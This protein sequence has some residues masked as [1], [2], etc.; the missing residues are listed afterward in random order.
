MA[1][2][3]PVVPQHLVLVSRGGEWRAPAHRPHPARRGA[4]WA[5]RADHPTLGTYYL[6]GRREAELLFTENETNGSASGASPT[7]APT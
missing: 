3:E 7:P 2:A 6:Y 4:A 1:P 5:V